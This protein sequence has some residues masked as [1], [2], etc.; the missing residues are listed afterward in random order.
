MKKYTIVLLVLAIACAFSVSAVMAAD[1]QKYDFDGKFTMEM[2]KGMDFK[3]EAQQE[4]A[5]VF[6][7][8]GNKS[9]VQ[10]FE[11]P[12]ID[13]DFIKEFNSGYESKG[14]KIISTDGKITLFE[15]D[16]LYVA[17]TYKDG[18]MVLS[19]SM[20]NDTALNSIKTVKF[21]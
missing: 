15:N 14:Y 5:V 18:I 2:E 13:S 1:L 9:C 12:G 10:Y 19:M 7:D 11:D 16:G 21:A 3:R 17:T 4:N 6:T 20:D 8:T